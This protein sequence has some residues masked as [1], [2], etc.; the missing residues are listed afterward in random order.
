MTLEDRVDQEKSQGQGSMPSL[1]KGVY[2]KMRQ[3]MRLRCWDKEKKIMLPSFPLYK[4]CFAHYDRTADMIIMLGTGLK[5]RTGKEI[6][7]GDIVRNPDS[8]LP[9][10][11]NR[12]VI[13]QDGCWQFLE[14]WKEKL[15]I[16]QGESAFSFSQFFEIIGNIYENPDLLEGK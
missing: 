7:E 15:S 4:A 2:D 8:E 1:W 10:D 14:A 3:N 5:D 11:Y 9:N 13:F 6:Y 12:K 16:T